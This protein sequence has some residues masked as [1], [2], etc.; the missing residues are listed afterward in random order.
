MNIFW[1]YE[2]QGLTDLVPSA[3]V[4]R[5]VFLF[6]AAR[7]QTE[8]FAMR[9]VDVVLICSHFRRIFRRAKNDMVVFDLD[10]RFRRSLLKTQIVRLG[11]SA[12]ATR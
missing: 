1:C 6:V 8:R 5:C 10:Y 9:V 4:G 12:L 2:T 11:P 7:T 3:L